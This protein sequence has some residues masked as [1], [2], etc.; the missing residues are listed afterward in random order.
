MR[1]ETGL[2]LYRYVA[3]ADALSFSASVGKGLLSRQSL[4]VPLHAK[5]LDKNDSKK[6]QKVNIL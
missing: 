6:E 4:W 5:S 3:G 1:R 2:I